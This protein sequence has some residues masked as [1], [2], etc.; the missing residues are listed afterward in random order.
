MR[1]DFSFSG[2]SGLLWLADADLVGAEQET[3]LAQQA[4]GT[5]V[6]MV[7]FPED[8]VANIRLVVGELEDEEEQ[9]WVGR[10]AGGVGVR[11]GQVLLGNVLSESLRDDLQRFRPLER[12]GRYKEGARFALDEGPSLSGSPPELLARRPE[13]GPALWSLSSTAGAADWTRSRCRATLLA[14]DPA[15][16]PRSGWIGSSTSTQEPAAGSTLSCICS[17]ATTL[18]WRI[19]RRASQSAARSDCQ[20]ANHK[21]P[22]PTGPNGQA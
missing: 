16:R 7:E 1:L 20:P 10:C 5:D 21:V 15:R 6:V 12:G 8:L 9:S 13:L 18:W 3:A 19:G 17:A 22:A 4:P 2:G 14:P 11:S